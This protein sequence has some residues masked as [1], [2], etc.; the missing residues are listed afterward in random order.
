MGK[1]KERSDQTK[2][3]QSEM[4]LCIYL[5]VTI[6]ILHQFEI[7]FQFYKSSQSKINSQIAE[8]IVSCENHNHKNQKN[9]I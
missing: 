5:K 2:H 1:Q 9:K 8:I 4:I 7:G 6:Y 3:A